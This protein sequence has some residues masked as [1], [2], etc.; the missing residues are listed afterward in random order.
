LDLSKKFYVENPA[1]WK[2]TLSQKKFSDRKIGIKVVKRGIILPA[3]PPENDLMWKGGVCDSDFNFI[4]GF[5]RLDPVLKRRGERFGSVESSYTVAREEIIQL[6]EDVIFGG[7]LIGHFGH[8][9]LECWS[10]LWFVVNHPE[11]PLKIL[12]ITT[13]H[14]GYHNWFDGFFRLMGIDLS[15]I[16]YVDKPVQCRSVIVPEQSSYAPISFTKEFLL[17]Y[18]AIRS[19]V[20]PANHKKLYLTRTKFEHD[21]SIGVHCYNEKYFEDFFVAH[22]FEAVSM[23]KLSV[24]EQISLIMGAE[25]IAATL[26][27]LTHWVMFCKPTAKFI[28]L[29][30]TNNYVS[31]YQCFIFE[32]FNFANYYIVDA[33]KNF[34]YAHR[35]LGAIML[36]SNKY[37]KKFATDYFGEQIEEDDDAPYFGDALDK[38]VNFWCR[39]YSDQKNFNIWVSSFKNMCNRIVRLEQE[40][41]KN[42]PL[43]VYQTHIAQK[44]WGT[45]KN[46]N[47]I[48]NALDEL[49]DIQAIKINFPNHKIYYAV[50][51]ND[52]EGWSKEVS[53]FQMAGT[54]GRSK[55]ITGI[56]IRLDEADAKE[57]N[58]FYRVHK[59]DGSWTAWAKNG[60]ELFS[61]AQKLNAVQIK[62]EI[63]S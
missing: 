35:T 40:L 1:D 41:N 32:A 16:I 34:M 22:G 3:H 55:S 36:G 37:W 7:A 27:T 54:T 38:Y 62:L 2:R 12:F 18:Q 57:F 10:R 14:G 48:S 11:L 33:S 8:F 21:D 56:K 17:P 42:R 43:L 51:Y 59:F 15:R 50:Y 25:E 45:W 61:D 23:E 60:A 20:K 28:M 53:N 6:D 4:A 47:Q 19:N 29:N 49:L 24:E 13:T 58:I 44:G 46:E 39:K 63:K 9:T 26:G 31:G 52:K 30:R 5:T